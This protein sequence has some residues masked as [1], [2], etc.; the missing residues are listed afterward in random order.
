MSDGPSPIDLE[1]FE[2]IPAAPGTALLRVTARVPVWAP[3]EPTLLIRDDARVHRLRPLPSPREPEGWLRAAY[4]VRTAVLDRDPS[5]AL[6]L[7]QGAV[8][9]LPEPRGRTRQS[10]LKQQASHPPE[11]KRSQPPDES[12]RRERPPRSQPPDE[13]IRR[14]R[15]S[16]SQPPDES[17]TR[18]EPTQRTD[19]EKLIHLQ[20]RVVEANRWALAAQR[21]TER[22]TARVREL[23][24]ALEEADEI[25]LIRRAATHRA[26]DRDEAEIRTALSRR[27]GRS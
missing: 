6:E 19:T 24:R 7:S 23:E 4:S 5:F 14:E 16:R 21:E 9:E 25:D 17:I 22:L 8:F 2:I 18:H 10:R 13:S 20:A 27:R 11:L 12:I 3:R 15:P 1:E 26:R